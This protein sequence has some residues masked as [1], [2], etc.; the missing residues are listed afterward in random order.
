MR[1]AAVKPPSQRAALIAQ[2]PTE[3]LDLTIV[4]PGPPRTKK[5][6]NQIITRVDALG[7]N[8]PRVIPS[9]AFLTWQ[10][11]AMWTLRSHQARGTWPLSG[12]LSIRAYFYLDVNDITAASAGDPTGYY[13]ALADCLEKAGVVQN[14]F[15]IRNWDGSRV[16][17]DR[18]H[19]RVELTITAAREW[20]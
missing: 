2:P 13:Q 16:W 4:I 3:G 10:D 8:R 17:L 19:P 14:D 5:T 11:A 18:R 7:R 15:Q 1:T 12:P 9:Q 6:S 20:W